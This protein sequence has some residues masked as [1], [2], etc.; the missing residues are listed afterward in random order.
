MGAAPSRKPAEEHLVNEKP[1]DLVLDQ[2]V[3]LPR[4]EFWGIPL[5]S[6]P[7]VALLGHLKFDTLFRQLLSEQV[8][9]FLYYLDDNLLIE[10]VELDYRVEP[11]A[12]L[13]G[14]NP[15]DRVLYGGLGD[16]PLFKAHLR[17]SDLPGSRVG[18]HDD[19][20]VAEIGLFTRIVRQ[21]RVVHHLKKGVVYV[22]VGLFDLIEQKHGIRRLPDTLG[23]Q[24]SLLVTDIAGRRAYEPRDR[25]LFLVFAHVESMELHTES[26]RKLAGELGLAHPGRPHE[27]KRGDRPVRVAES[28]P[29]PLDRFTHVRDRRVLAENLL[30][31]LDLDVPEPAHF[32]RGHAL[33]RYLR[34]FGHDLLD[35]IHGDCDGILALHPG[36]AGVRA[37]LVD[38]VDRLVRKVAVVDVF[39][40]QLHRHAKRLVRIVYIVV[41]LVTVFQPEKYLVGLLD[42]RFRYLDFLEPA[43]E[44]TVLVEILLILFI[45]GRADALDLAR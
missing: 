22:L 40:R 39:R 45:R 23:Q 27:K 2:A 36:H 42:G 13:R 21:G 16:L 35:V 26:G 30:F 31:E 44:G 29:V 15:V 8:Y 11:V 10:V 37:R 33:F 24:T 43:R 9:R 3:D 25:V 34:N 41:F 17:L 18:G 12:E 19:D 6:E 32:G 38:D 20:D 5:S 4:A 7:A 14:E 28:G 1:L